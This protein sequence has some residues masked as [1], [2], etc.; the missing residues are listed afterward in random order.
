MLLWFFGN[1][2]SFGPLSLFDLANLN[3]F[4][5]NEI[6]SINSSYPTEAL[7][8]IACTVVS[9]EKSPRSMNSK[10]SDEFDQSK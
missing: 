10:R 7:S 2:I 8:Y 4:L 1:G 6:S 9:I 5:K 3:F